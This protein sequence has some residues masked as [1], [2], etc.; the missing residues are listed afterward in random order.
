MLDK[1]KFGPI[2]VPIVTPYAANQIVDHAKLRDLAS[3][4]RDG[5]SGQERGGTWVQQELAPLSA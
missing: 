2:Y 3:D 1:D 4:H 5:R